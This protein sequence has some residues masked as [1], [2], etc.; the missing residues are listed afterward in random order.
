MKQPQTLAEL[1]TLREGRRKHLQ[2]ARKIKHAVELCALHCREELDDL[3][4][5]M[6]AGVRAGDIQAVK[7]MLHRAHDQSPAEWSFNDED[8]VELALLVIEYLDYALL[9]PVVQVA[10]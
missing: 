4:A 9:E 10:A 5:E 8:G 6:I 1:L 3:G 7:E 2:V